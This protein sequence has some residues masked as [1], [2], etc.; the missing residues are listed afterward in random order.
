[1]SGA[2]VEEAVLNTLWIGD[3]LGPVERAC[4]R[5]FLAHGHRLVLWCYARPSGVP[6]GVLVRDAAEILPED[7]II[8]HRGGSAALFANWF[9]YELQKRGRGIWI[10]CDLYALKPLERLPEQLFAWSAA[11]EINTAILRLPPDSPLIA[12]LVEMFEEKKIPPGLPWR[13]RLAARWRLL[14]SGRSGLSHMPW[15]SAG[16]RAFT[17]LARR[18]GLDRFALPAETF[19]PVHW[20]DAAWIL[21][22]NVALEE[23][24]TPDTL[25][26]HLWN[27]LIKGFKDRPAPPGSFLARLQ[28]EGADD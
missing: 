16:P 13:A 25:A 10:D 20:R 21:D 3:R 24:V 7:R 8:R 15:G 28:A 17:R 22:P 1:M 2:S 18:H 27:E 12:P 14:R 9:R 26:I 5:S 19:Y 11:D 4:L 6:D 23:V